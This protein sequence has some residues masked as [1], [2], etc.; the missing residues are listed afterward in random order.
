V[1]D[2]ARAAGWRLT[3]EEL[4]EVDRLAPQPRAESISRS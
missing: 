4:D 1:A 3:E 2:N